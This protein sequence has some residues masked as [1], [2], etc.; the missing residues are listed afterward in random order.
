MCIVQWAFAWW[1]LTKTVEGNEMMA[2]E[3]TI[4]AKQHIKNVLQALI[5]L[6]CLL[7][8]GNL[9]VDM[10]HNIVGYISSTN[11]KLDTFL[12]K[13][14]N[15]FIAMF[16]AGCLAGVA[17]NYTALAHAS[18]DFKT[19]ESKGRIKNGWLAFVACLSSALVI[20]IILVIVHAVGVIN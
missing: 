12:Y 2:T 13:V 4:Q 8:I 11:L 5:A 18:D 7:F 14:C 1:S 10:T 19:S 20:N 17:F 15:E 6:I 9:I 16:S 3:R